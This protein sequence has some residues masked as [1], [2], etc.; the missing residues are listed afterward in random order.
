MNSIK[1]QISV[2]VPVFNVERYLSRCIDSLLV[3]TYKNIEIILINDDSTDNSPQICD[4]YSKQY[5]NI[6]VVNLKNSG[7][8]VSGVR[9]AGLNIASGE[10]LAFVDSDDYVH[11]DLFFHLHNLLEKYPNANIA[12]CS[13]KKIWE[14][15]IDLNQLFIS[16]EILL[17]DLEAIN[18]IIED[19]N[20]TA[21]WSKLYKKSIFDNLRFPLGKHNEDMFLMPF[22][23]K[24]ARNIVYSPQQ[25]YYYFQDSDSLCRSEF[26][27]NMLDMLEALAIW[28]KLVATDYPSLLK[29]AKSHYCSTVINSCQYLANKN[30]KIGNDKFKYY[31]NIVNLEFNN[32]IFSEFISNNNKIKL[33]L[34]K[35]RL[36][37]FV[38][39]FLNNFNFEK[40]E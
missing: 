2:I 15:T 38:F 3:Q 4:T 12:F 35:L 24:T 25:L 28:N 26:N 16:N 30:D 18:L 11:C 29:K 21:V 8:G 39:R 9:N 22:I 36:F 13:Y 1:G 10:Y 33:I 34:F 5:S 40:Y 14:K 7:I 32:L 20:K 17:N 27:Y 6:K 31:Q 23:F 19:Q 37:K